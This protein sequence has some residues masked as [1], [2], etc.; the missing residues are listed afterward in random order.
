MRS[1]PRSS[2]GS[3]DLAR[4][5]NARDRGTRPAA[6]TPPIKIRVFDA[7][8]RDLARDFERAPEFD[9]TALFRAVYES[10]F[11]IAGGS[12][13][14]SYNDYEVR[15]RGRGTDERRVGLDGI[16]HVA[17]ASFAPFIVGGSRAARH[18]RFRGDLVPDCTAR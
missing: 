15:H 4:P 6:T 9:Q 12:R 11:G 2:N 18:R 8:W 17:A 7:T 3:G 10:E 1:A 16:A 13:T 14:A 5:E